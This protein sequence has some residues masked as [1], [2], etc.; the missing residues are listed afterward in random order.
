MRS[1]IPFYL[2]RWVFVAFAAMGILLGHLI[3]IGQTPASTPKASAMLGD[4]FAE[5]EKLGPVSRE[6]RERALSKVLEGERHLWTTGRSRNMT[7]AQGNIRL[8]RQAFLDALA[9]DPTL[10]EAYTALAEIE[11]ML[12]PGETEIDEAIALLKVAIA[13]NPANFGS[14]QL[15]ARLYSLRSRPG[16]GPFDPQAGEKAVDEWSVVA[17]LD[18]R[19]AEAWAFL[20]AF[21][22]RFNDKEKRI[23]ALRNW[24]SSAAPLDTQFYNRV[25]GQNDSL[26]P[27]SAALKLGSALLESGRH[28]EAVD[29][30][31]AVIA[32]DPDNATA[33]EILRGIAESPSSESSEKVTGSLQQAVFANPG[34]GALVNLLAELYERGG[35]TEEA[36]RLFETVVSRLSENDV[37]SA[38]NIRTGQG[39]FLF[40]RERFREAASAYKGALAMRGLSDREAASD[41]D[42]A[43]A[44]DVI[45]KLIRAEKDSE[46]NPGVIA[47]IERSRRVFG[48][49]DLFADRQLI[50][51]YRETGRRSEALSAVRAARKRSPKDAGFI[52]LEATILTELGR[53]DEGIEIVRA[54]MGSGVA[55]TSGN[56]NRATVSL[57]GAD[58]L[59][60]LL[61]ISSLYAKAERGN[62]AIQAANEALKI[63][64]GAE[65]RQIAQIA[66]ATAQN[67]AGEHDA[68]EATLNSI[69][70][71][72]PNNPIA[73]NN[74]G[75][76]LL[77]R[78]VRLEEATRMIEK[79]VATDPTNPSFLDSLGWAKFKFGDLAEAER[80]LKEA[81]RFDPN[82]AT[83]HEHLG[84]VY[85]KQ[86]KQASAI[87]S[88]E[89]ALKL[90]TS[91]GEIK[92]I[93]D[94]LK[95]R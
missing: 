68:A 69:L 32:D 28:S 43:F 6:E 44:A 73:L 47:A 30:I 29:T 4:R 10:A 5:R 82:S 8:A 94:K 76:F 95:K 81:S 9:I 24:L 87:T 17:S 46:N 45:S 13:A 56:G 19:N 84:D 20:A 64:R 12:R 26:S 70:T 88:W 62:E 80:L 48:S 37:V 41:E 21:Y 53:V 58:D 2:K 89:R 65:R 31:A 75:Y 18:P 74:L 35:R 27:E 50:G 36:K 78:N 40:G 66:L 60:N 92:R 79:A 14:R 72:S 63:A 91:P 51:F 49:D 34:N 55:T 54:A 33:I 3:A 71:E 11:I 83:I 39:D 52:R 16:R 25:M 7:R 57:P 59:S 42:R 22:D 1:S 85:S 86:G 61:F 77:E 90:A 67:A 15:L 38:S 23:D 93:K